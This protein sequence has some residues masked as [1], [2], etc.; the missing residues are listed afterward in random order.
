MIYEELLSRGSQPF[1]G[2]QLHIPSVRPLQ[3]NITT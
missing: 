1:L 3:D 2:A